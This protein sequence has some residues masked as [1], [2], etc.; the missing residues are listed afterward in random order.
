MNTISSAL[1]LVVSAALLA[2][3]TALG[4]YAPHKISNLPGWNPSNPTFDQY[5]GYVTVNES[6]GRA[7]FYWLTESEKNPSEDPLVIWLNGGPGC[8]SVGG[9]L[10]SELGPFYPHENGTLVPN[11]WA[12]NQIAN[13]LFIESPAGVGFSYSNTSSDYKVGDK[14]TSED[15]YT[16]LV[17]FLQMYPEF[18]KNPVYISGESY[19][20]HYVPNFAHTIVTNQKNNPSININFKGFMVGNA[21]TVAEIDN[22]GAAFYWWS[23]GI[24]Y[25]DAFFGILQNCNMS[26]VGP[27]KKSKTLRSAYKLLEE[28][29][30]EGQ[31][32]DEGDCQHY[33]DLAMQQ[34]GNINIYDIYVD[35]CNSQDEAVAN[36]ANQLLKYLGR[37]DG[38]NTEL[39]APG[40]GL[41]RSGA[42]RLAGSDGADGGSKNYDPCIS[43]K[44][45]KYLNRQ[46][47]QDAIHARNLG[48]PWRD[49]SNIVDYSR[50]SLL[51]SMLPVYRDLLKA[52]IQMMV[53]SGDVDA[54]VPITGTRA[55]LEVLDLPVKSGWRSYT[56]DGQVGGYTLEYEGLTFTSVR[57]AGHMVPYMQQ[58]RALHIFTQFLKNEPM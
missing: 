17:R 25:D 26:N 19:G 41:R 2:S 21:W 54:I 23:H 47:V 32:F 20:G 35:V 7:L 14:R 24:N 28:A 33:Q 8:S 13:L 39:P 37:K 1:G 4:G 48:R 55:W 43:N 11:P 27:L 15:L 22:T 56:V 46:D 6:H 36:H 40:S 3:Q 42:R 34:M 31:S 9:G 57:N 51:S 53:Y 16:F 44:V 5:A 30:K 29:Q 10:M 45:S 49:C 38:Q 50:E 58:S 12:W 18:Q 52:N